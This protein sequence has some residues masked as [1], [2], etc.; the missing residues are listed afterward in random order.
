MKTH[1]DPYQ[2]HRETP[3]QSIWIINHHKTIYS[4]HDKVSDT[5]LKY[6]QCCMKSK[7][8]NNISKST[9]ILK[10]HTK[11]SCCIHDAVRR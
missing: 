1:N 6:V 9:A 4:M 3:R 2:K 10:L 8:I 7:K 11:G 5:N